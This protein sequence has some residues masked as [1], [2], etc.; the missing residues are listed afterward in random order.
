MRSGHSSWLLNGVM[1]YRSVVFYNQALSIPTLSKFYLTVQV[2]FD[3]GASECD[4]L[5]VHEM[6]SER[7]LLGGSRSGISAPISAV[8]ADLPNDDLP[9]G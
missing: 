8:G 4:R 9:Y 3:T 2:E 7:S 6:I 5:T 1:E